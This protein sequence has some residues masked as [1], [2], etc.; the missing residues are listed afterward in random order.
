MSTV[1]VKT[2]K[3]KFISEKNEYVSWYLPLAW[4]FVSDNPPIKIIYNS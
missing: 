4:Y 1:T 2:V 3:R